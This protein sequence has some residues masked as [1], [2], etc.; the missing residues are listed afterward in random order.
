[1][2]DGEAWNQYLRLGGC[3]AISRVKRFRSEQMIAQVRRLRVHARRETCSRRGE[4]LQAKASDSFWLF[5]CFSARPTTGGGLH[6]STVFAAATL[7]KMHSIWWQLKALVATPETYRAG[8]HELD[9]QTP[10]SG[11]VITTY[12]CGRAGW[13]SSPD[14]SARHRRFPRRA[15][16]YEHHYRVANQAS[17]ASSSCLTS[18]LDLGT[19]RPYHETPVVTARAWLHVLGVAR[20]SGCT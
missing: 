17:G 15:R 10:S 11:S 20:G 16:S 3:A 6:S 13:S 7:S 5:R 2:G 4:S 18:T 12:C 14:T 19:S 9:H 1:M 8:R